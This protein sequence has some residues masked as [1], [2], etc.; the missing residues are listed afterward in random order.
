M[1]LSRTTKY[2]YIIWDWN[3]TLLDDAN[4]N[5]NAVNKM[6]ERRKLPK[7]SFDLYL[8]LVE[9]PI[10]GFYKKAGFDLETENFTET[11]IEFRQHYVAEMEKGDL[12]KSA[13]EVLADI[14]AQ[15]I[16][17]IIISSFH[18]ESLRLFV[19]KYGITE[20]FDEI[21]GKDDL[22]GEK[23]DDVAKA[24]IERTGI[25]AA[26]VLLIGDLT[27]DFEVAESI[28]CDCVLIPNGYHKK[29]ALERCGV[30]VLD[31]ISE[32]PV[33]LGIKINF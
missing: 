29:Q 18:E 7:L 1:A 14:K 31:D 22:L 6:L 13:R 26:T 11:S 28:G 15:G 2:E 17:Q 24:W 9:I 5:L 30:P 8:D 21:L 19:D 27:H 25:D 12:M 16:R 10:L 20:Y 3:G 32:V 33:F 4:A 23:K